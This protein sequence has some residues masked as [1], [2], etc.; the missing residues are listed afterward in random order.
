MEV[1]K[2]DIANLDNRR[3]EGFLVGLV[4]ALSLLFVAFE[5]T[6]SPKQS[7]DNDELLDQMSQE[8]EMMST[9]D[10]HDMVSVQ[11]SSASKAITQNVKAT[12]HATDQPQKIASTTSPLVVGDGDALNKEANVKEEVAETPSQNPA[13]VEDNTVYKVQTVEKLPVFPGGWTTLMQWLTR[14]LHY[15]ANA[16]QQKIQGKVVVSFIINKDG[17]VS[18]VKLEKSV[19]PSLDREALRVIKMMPKWQPAI[20]HDKPCRCM[21]VIPVVFSL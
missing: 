7:A 3:G 10:T 18:Q 2:S 14:N 21:F 4:V 13:Q 12:D 17:T 15:P 5:Y 11:E 6:T 20:M 1:K 9:P 16:Q 8:M 19:D